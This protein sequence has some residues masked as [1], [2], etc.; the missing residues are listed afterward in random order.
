MYRVALDEGLRGGLRVSTVRLS[1]DHGFGG[2]PLW[3]ET[4]V[5]PDNGWDDLACER[6]ETEDQAIAGHAAMLERVKAGEFTGDESSLTPEDALI[7]V[8][9]LLRNEVRR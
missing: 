7:F 2:T 5:F 9:S 1:C 6:Y 3:Y 4:M 8:D